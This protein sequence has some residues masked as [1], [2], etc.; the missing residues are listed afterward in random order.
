MYGLAI[1]ALCCVCVCVREGHNEWTKCVSAAGYPNTHAH[2]HTH[3]HTQR[4]RERERESRAEQSAE[5]YGLAMRHSERGSREQ[6]DWT[7]QQRQSGLGAC[8]LLPTL[9]D[10][11][12]LSL[13]LSHTHTHICGPHSFMFIH[14]LFLPPSLLFHYTIIIISSFLIDRMCVHIITAHTTYTLS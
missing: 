6:R 14:H 3:T 2:A 1:K 7:E 10:I 12:S 5:V 4:E 8:F 13:S 11:C 9:P